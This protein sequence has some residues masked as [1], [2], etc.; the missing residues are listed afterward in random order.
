MQYGDIYLGM[1]HQREKWRGNVS[2]LLPSLSHRS[3]LLRIWVSSSQPGTT[4]YPRGYVTRDIF[5]SRD[6]FIFTTGGA[7]GI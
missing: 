2:G 6:F 7:I 5:I 1:G 3:K 4:L